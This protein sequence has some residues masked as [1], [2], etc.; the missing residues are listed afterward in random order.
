M[1][2]HPILLSIFSIFN[3]LNTMMENFLKQPSGVLMIFFVLGFIIFIETG[4]VIFPFLPG[5]SILFFVGG[6]SASPISNGRLNIVLL[7]VV[8]G[9][10]AFLAN[11][12]NFEIGRRF[13]EAIPKH[14][15]L[16]RF[17]KPEYMEDAHK[18]FQKW[19]SWAIFLG[20]F[21][22]IIRTIVPFTAGAGKMSHRQFIL[23]NF[24]GGFAWVT[25]AL[26][27]GFLFGQIPFV[28]KNLELIMIAIVVISFLPAVIGGLRN[29]CVRRGAKVNDN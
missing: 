2:F 11:L 5:D 27:A 18:F 22:P 24:L 15:W 12:V 4:I 17:L 10:V 13:G 28:K 23:F 26:G 7:I 1:F 14:R 16:S 29:Y 21:M 8:M 9:C 20:R 3:N 6:L 25:V 19:G